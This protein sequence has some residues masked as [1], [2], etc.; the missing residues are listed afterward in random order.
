[1]PLLRELSDEHIAQIVPLF[2][3]REYERDDV[4]LWQGQSSDYVY[5][6]KSGIVAISRLSRS[7][8][9]TG[10]TPGQES[11]VLA[12]LKQTDTMGDITALRSGGTAS[13][14]ATALSAVNVLLLKK[15]DFLKLLVEYPAVALELARIMAQRLLSNE[16]RASRASGTRISLLLNFTGAEISPLGYAQAL[17]LS[18]ATQRS[19]VYTELPDQDHLQ[20]LFPT[21]Q[22]QVIAK[23]GE[24]DLML[25]STS[26]G[27]S[28]SLRVTVDFDFLSANYEQIV[29]AVDHRREEI[30]N[31]LAPH[32][33]QIVLIAPPSAEAWGQVNE[34]ISELRTQINPEKVGVFTAVYRSTAA[35][36]D[37]QSPAPA[38]FDLPPL[39]IGTLKDLQIESLPAP[40]AAMTKSLADRLGRSNQVSIFIPTTIDVNTAVDTTQYVDRTLAFLGERFGGATTNQARG[41]WNSA[42]SGLVGESIHIVRSYATQTDLDRFLREILDYVESLKTELRQEAM[43][44]EINQKLMLI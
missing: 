26:P 11:K 5:F 15:A 28:Q 10:V 14:T 44:V 30:I 41:V 19:T 2:R 12:Y 3:E 37:L 24:V 17:A 27:L 33:D 36:A 8:A 9:A 1:M 6:I 32:A 38:D 35:E 39:E 31:T 7:E 4:L 23:S 18:A 34:A 40:L 42:E 43:A 21:E 20:A 16:A 29:I 22:Q 13:A 25:D